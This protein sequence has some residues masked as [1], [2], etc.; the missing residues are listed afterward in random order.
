VTDGQGNYNLDL[1]AGNY[2]IEALKDGYISQYFSMVSIGGST[3]T[4]QNASITPTI[5]I[6]ET[7]FVLTWDER[8]GDL[9]SHLL[10]PDGTDI[11]W[12]SRGNQSSS[13]YTELDVDRTNI[14]TGSGNVTFGP[15]TIT[16]YKPQSG[17]YRYFVHDYSAFTCNRKPLNDNDAEFQRDYCVNPSPGISSSS[18]KVQIYFENRLVKEYNAPLYG[19]G[20]YWNVFS[21]DGSTGTITTIY[22]LFNCHFHDFSTYRY[23]I[24]SIFICFYNGK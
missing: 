13:P 17:T 21:Y 10:T 12:K 3:T 18:A 22:P 23:A 19:T 1:P 20:L 24:S 5:N 15:E 4:N 11:Y 7:R 8:P 6:G 14:V 9:D 2:T 16:I